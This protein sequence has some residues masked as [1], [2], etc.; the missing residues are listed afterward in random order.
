MRT[1]PLTRD[2]IKGIAMVTMLLN[3]ISQIFMT[4]GTFWAELFLDVGWFTCITM[5]YFLVEGYGY[6][7]NKRRYAGR[8]A[9]FAILSQPACLL[10]FPDVATYRLNILFALLLCFGLL[11]VREKIPQRGRRFFV[12]VLFFALSLFCDWALLAPA[13]TLLFS[14]A[15]KDGRKRSYAF[16]IAALL[17][18]GMNLLGGIGRFTAVVNL[19]YALASMAGMAL[20]AVVICGF[21]N[22]RRA[23]HGRTFAKWFFYVFYPAHLVVLGVI[24]LLVA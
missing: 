9:I 1:K 7:S 24:R 15:G 19:G 16:L 3:Y 6:T 10:A 13:F 21:Y 14:W 23:T 11:A 12:T 18:G 8:L 20:S 22:G 4:P 17:F 2:A 5:C